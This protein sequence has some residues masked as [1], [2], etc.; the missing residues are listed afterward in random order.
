MKTRFFTLSKKQKKLLKKLYINPLTIALLSSLLSF[1][2][3]VSIAYSFFETVEGFRLGMIFSSTI[4]FI[5]ALPISAVLVSY[6]KK[7]EKQRKQIKVQA[8]ELEMANQTR[9][10]FF[11]IISHDLRSP[12]NVLLGLSEVLKNDF[13]EFSQEELKEN[14]QT[15]YSTSKQA[16]A[17]LDNLLIWSGLQTKRM[18]Q[19]ASVFDMKSVLNRNIELFKGQARQKDIELAMHYSSK[20]VQ[21]LADKNMIDTVIRNLISNAIKFT[22]GGVITI[23]LEKNSTKCY[24]YVAD[25]GVGMSIDILNTMFHVGNNTSTDG[26]SGEKGTGLGLILCKE[27]VELNSGEIWVESKENKG[28]KFTFSVPLAS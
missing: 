23:G 5:L 3:Y 1:T 9:N 21:A 27:F 24:V 4:P 19:H 11:S 7:T 18:Q 14:I 2:I 17:L 10:K 15:I 20:E 8:E 22:D 28:S 12:F 13:E 16:Y 6:Y 25:T 26:T